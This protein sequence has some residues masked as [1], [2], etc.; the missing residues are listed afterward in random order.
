M[1]AP[2]LAFARGQGHPARP[3]LFQVSEQSLELQSLKFMHDIYGDPRHLTPECRDQW[4]ANM[5][6]LT[7]F[8][9]RVVRGGRR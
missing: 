3:Q 6:L 9:A 1:S 8:V 4:Y 5:G 2:K 7:E